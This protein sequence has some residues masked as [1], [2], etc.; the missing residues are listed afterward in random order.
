MGSAEAEP[1]SLTFFFPYREVSG[2]PMLFTRLA[3]YLSRHSGREIN[4]VDY[5]DGAMAREVALNKHIQLIPFEDGSITKI[6][7]HSVLIFQSFL[8]TRFKNELLIS[9]RTKILFWT[10]HQDNLIPV[11]LPIPILREIE[12]KSFWFYKSF[13]RLFAGKSLKNT[14]EV[15]SLLLENDALYFMDSSTL[16]K[17]NKY[18]F[19]R[20]QPNDFLPIL[21]GEATDK[22]AKPQ[23]HDQLNF[24]WIGRLCDF[25]SYILIYTIKRVFAYSQKEKRK[26]IYHIVGDGEFYNEVQN[27]VKENQYFQLRMHGAI[28]PERLDSFL[29]SDVDVLTAMGTSVLEGAKLGIPSIV[30]DIS[31][32]PIKG[33][34]RFRWI[35]ETKDLDL[36]HQISEQDFSPGNKSLEDMIE[37][38]LSQYS[39]LSDQSF[40]Y[41]HQNHNISSVAQKLLDAVSESSLE[42]GM[43]DP[44]IFKISTVR[45]VY[46][47]I[48]GFR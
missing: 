8:P 31:Y 14:L 37:N 11:L 21:A 20:H 16:G 42:F 30:L 38:I 1:R 24:G 3:E 26:V 33:D 25:K 46:N 10:L 12:I 7:E 18:L 5:K 39:D 22:K 40:E 9:P 4:L 19:L 43:I 28:S 47:R 13:V 17:T 15:V 48:K 23:A 41:F 27:C 2:V 45:K 44:Q 34:Y 36:A 32:K 35:F 6:P 29:M